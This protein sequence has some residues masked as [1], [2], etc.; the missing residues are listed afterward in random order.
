MKGDEGVKRKG[1]CYVDDSVASLERIAQGRAICDDGWLSSR[2]H[3][4]ESY[5]EQEKGIMKF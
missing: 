1:R 2:G 3:Y 5:E 4:E